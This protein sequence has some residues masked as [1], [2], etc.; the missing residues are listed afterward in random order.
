MN[1]KKYTLNH[2]DCKFSKYINKYT[3]KTCTCRYS[4]PVLYNY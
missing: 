1:T 2:M 3:V 4:I